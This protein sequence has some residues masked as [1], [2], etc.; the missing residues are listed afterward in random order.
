M[1]DSF[2]TRIYEDLVRCELPEKNQTSGL[3]IGQWG[4]L[5]FIFYY[6]QFYDQSA[7]KAIGLLEKL[8]GQLNESGYTNSTYCNGLTGPLWLL[9]HLSKYE[10]IDVDFENLIG[11]FPDIAILE[12]RQHLHAKNYDFLHGSTGIVNF[13]VNLS[14]LKEVRE[15]L[16]EYV[17]CLMQDTVLT[18]TGRSFPFFY[19]DESLLSEKHTEAI[20]MAHGT[21]SLQIILT[22]IH[23]IGIAQ[24]TCK[25][26]VY[27]SID[28]LLQ[29]ENKP[30]VASRFPFS[31]D[32]K[33]EVS[34][35]SWCYGDLCVA[36]SLWHCGKHFKEEKWQLKAREIL[37]SNL[38]RTNDDTSGVI[39]TCLCHGTAGNA[40]IYRWFWRETGEKAFFDCAEA[41]YKQT[42]DMIRFPEKPNMCGIHEWD[43]IHKKWQYNWTLLNGSA[44]VGLA[45]LS[46]IVDLPLPW[47]D[48]LLIA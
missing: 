13:L 27:E 35:L 19:F 22:K 18:K 11:D 26:L 44:G 46:R 25:K 24:D 45:L 17:Q 34:R 40:V 48:F 20:G 28:Y 32:E 33:G 5:F 12:S 2:V 42:F 29:H 8:F 30:K 6:E 38:K 10:F 23:Q 1:T 31:C 37:R 43:G 21:C 36:L 39:D 14:Q 9:H 15:H 7:N 4:V 47:E 16:N 41:W 3:F